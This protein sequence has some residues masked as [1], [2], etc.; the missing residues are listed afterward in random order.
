MVSP[1]TT[2]RRRRK[3]AGTAALSSRR[4]SWTSWRRLLRMP[5]TPT[6]THARCSPSKR[7]CQRIGY[8]CGS[9]TVVRSG[10]RR[11]NVG[12]GPPSWRSTGC[13][14][15]WCDTRF[16]CRRPSSKALR[17]TT[18]S[19]PGYSFKVLEQHSRRLHEDWRLQVRGLQRAGAAAM[20]GA[21][22]AMGG[23]LG[24]ACAGAGSEDEGPLDIDVGTEP[25][26]PARLY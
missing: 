19:H 23:A 18:P 24:G 2:A 21:G 13:T 1:L 12:G 15:P 10:A 25:P 5:T 14:A 26:P 3:N 22:A 17:R 7:T 4:T 16:L 6:C 8:R 11:R 20:A 9:R